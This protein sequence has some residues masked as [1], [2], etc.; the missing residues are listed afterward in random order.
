MD[1]KR[2][3][4]SAKGKD[5]SKSFSKARLKASWDPKVAYPKTDMLSKRESLEPSYGALDT[6]FWLVNIYIYI[7]DLKKYI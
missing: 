6:T 4:T 2:S 5:R 7:F 1:K 3:T